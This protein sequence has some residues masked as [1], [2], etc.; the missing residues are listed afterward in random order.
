HARSWRTHFPPHLASDTIQ[1]NLNL[2]YI[3]NYILRIVTVESKAEVK[4][5]GR[6]L[7]VD[8]HQSTTS[9]GQSQHQQ[10]RRRHRDEQQ[11]ESQKYLDNE[12]ASKERYAELQQQ[13]RAKIL[14]FSDEYSKAM[15]DDFHVGHFMC[16]FCNKNLAGQRYVLKDEQSY[17]TDCYETKFANTCEDCR[18]P[19]GIDS[20]DL[21]YKDKHWHDACFVCSR[22]SASLID[23]PFGTKSEK[24][25]CADCY[26]TSF[27][28]KCDAC[29][30]PFR[31]GSKKMEYR[32]RQWH[33]SCFCCCVC[34]NTI[35]S[36]SFIPKD[37]SIY[38]IKCYE[39]KFATKCTKC[40]LVIASGGVTFRNEPW[41]RECFQCCHCAKSLAGVRFTTHDSDK[42]DAAQYNKTG[43]AHNAYCIDCYSR[44]F[45][46]KCFACSEPITGVGGT[47][48]VTFEDRNWHNDCFVCTDCRQ[49][50]VGKGFIT[51]G[52][53]EILCAECARA[54][55]R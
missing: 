40:K 49:S 55:L 11:Q 14:I 3:E 27:A 38:C 44:F 32:G 12:R 26:D 34:K 46:K 23:K 45:A 2:Y 43:Q 17:C 51:D 16:Q 13:N 36:N 53:N 18:K 8:Q 33:D 28:T 6:R 21:S 30:N 47:R 19:I 20:R 31:A 7:G 42:N 41:H 24:I 5:L 52:P 48:F 4:N 25:Y 22:C 29:Q 15:G 39:D 1:F 9:G 50:L 37:E 10:R 35:G 54:K